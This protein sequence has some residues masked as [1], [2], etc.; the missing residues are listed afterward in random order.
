LHSLKDLPIPEH[1]FQLLIPGLPAE[2]P[3]LHSLREIIPQLPVF[4]SEQI[5]SP[6][7]HPLFV[8]R[9]GQLSLLDGYLQKALGGEGSVVFVAG[10]PGAGKPP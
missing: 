5:E 8:A 1:I 2:F 7:E 3:A 9:A 10:N 6:G 4:L